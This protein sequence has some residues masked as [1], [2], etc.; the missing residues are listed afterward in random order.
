M[1]VFWRY[2]TA[3]YLKMAPNWRVVCPGCGD[4]CVY[5]HC[6]ERILNAKHSGRDR[7]FWS[8]YQRHRKHN[9]TTVELIQR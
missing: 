6:A 9:H 1:V 3:G 7:E 2:D 5:R 8:G 4:T